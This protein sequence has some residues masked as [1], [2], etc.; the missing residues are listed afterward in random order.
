MGAL[1]AE[2]RRGWRTRF[3]L[4]VLLLAIVGVPLD[5]GQEPFAAH[6][7]AVADGDSITVLRDKQ[8]LKVRL[9]G[10][11]CPEGG[12]AFG[13]AAKRFTSDLVFGR[14]VM[15]R[16]RGTDR[17]GRMV[18]D[19]TVDGR[20]V[21]LALVE[22]GFAWHFLRYSDDP[23]LAAA[24]QAARAAR[25]G[26]WAD[27]NPIPP[28][29]YRRPVPSAEGPFRGNARSRVFHSPV[30]QHYRCANCTL[31]FASLEAAREAAFRPHRD[32]VQEPNDAR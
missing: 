17:Y 12:Q 25:R 26:L 21:G 16:P 23:R 11:D 22:A 6:V 24:E 8:Q 15:V 13:A 31:E 4:A 30:C 2:P 5:A 1:R 32:C 28:W 3:A 7:V 14:E 27:P 18:A 9:Q 29:E 19:V 10:V 20:D